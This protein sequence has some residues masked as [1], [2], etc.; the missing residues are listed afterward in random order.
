MVL[1]FLFHSDR[2]CWWQNHFT[3]SWPLLNSVFMTRCAATS[4]RPAAEICILSTTRG[5]IPNQH[6]TPLHICSWGD[7]TSSG[8]AYGFHNRHQNLF[9]SDWSSR[10]HN[11]AVRCSDRDPVSP[12]VFDFFRTA[13]SRSSFKSSLHSNIRKIFCFQQSSAHQIMWSNPLCTV[14]VNADFVFPMEIASISLV[15]RI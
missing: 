3:S 13:D 11:T 15:Y 2:W 14:A 7:L 9:P 12:I 5:I 8:K 1:A 10:F 6:H 4:A